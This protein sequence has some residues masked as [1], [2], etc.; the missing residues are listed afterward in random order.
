MLWY[1]DSMRA[2]RGCVVIHDKPFDFISEDEIY[3]I[4]QSLNMDSDKSFA[5]FINKAQNVNDAVSIS[6]TFVGKEASVKDVT[7]TGNQSLSR[8]VTIVMS[9]NSANVFLAHVLQ[10]S[11]KNL[12]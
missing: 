3:K 2:N 9:E 12:R 11:I 8:Q 1:E 6:F 5:L 4:R 7:Q 10:A